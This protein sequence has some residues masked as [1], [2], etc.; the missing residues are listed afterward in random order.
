VALPRVDKAPFPWFGGKRDAAETVWKLLGDPHNYVE[1][2]AGSLAVLLHPANR[3][4]YYETVNDA[5]GLLINAWRA[6]Q[7]HPEET[8]H[9]TSWPI[10]E[11]DRMARSLAVLQWRE[12][13]ELE[14]LMADPEWC[15]PKI[16]GWWLYS[17]A[18][19]I[20]PLTGRGGWMV[21]PVSG[22]I[23]RRTTESV[24]VDRT[25]PQL[26]NGQGVHH[27]DTRELGVSKTLGED[28]E[29]HPI[30]MPELHK[31][32]RWLSA[33]LRHVRI[34]NGDWSRVCRRSVLYTLQVHMG[35][36]YAGVFLDP[37]YGGTERAG[38]LYACDDGAV[39]AEVRDWC[40]ENGDDP[41][42]RIVL[43]G[44]DTEHEVLERHGW[45][46][47]QWFTP[48]ALKGG[49]AKRGGEHQQHRERLWVS[50]HCSLPEQGSLFEL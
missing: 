49:M 48:G 19:T 3:P 17:V 47:Y 20:G 38:G 45:T 36:G 50:P 4:S 16:A 35:D 25:L 30:V 6:I 41:R 13:R 5:D 40:L 24:S 23:V 39:A 29:F 22:R 9:H 37:P 42:L 12:E 33:R 7:L 18:C 10:T 14:R 34:I 21:D 2:F 31:W 43:A 8:A 28:T 15:D 26:T 32:F 44:F 1:P 46:V 11:A 27:P